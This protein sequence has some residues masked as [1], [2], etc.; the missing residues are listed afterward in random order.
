LNFLFAMVL[1]LL[2]PPRCAELCTLT[3]RWG[4]RYTTARDYMDLAREVDGRPYEIRNDEAGAE[5][6]T[7]EIAVVDNADLI[8]EAVQQERDRVAEAEAEGRYSDVLRID[9]RVAPE[10]HEKCRAQIK[11]LGLVEVGARLYRAL[12]P[13]E[14]NA[15]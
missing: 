1:G 13:E 9:C 2:K 10:L 3:V 12:F 8:A 14:F 4:M 7:D 5:V 6:A 11:Q 15:D